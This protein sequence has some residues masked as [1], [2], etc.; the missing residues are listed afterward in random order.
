LEK[1]AEKTSAIQSLTG[2]IDRRTALYNQ[3][4][5]DYEAAKNC[6]GYGSLAEAEETEKEL[7]ATLKEQTGYESMEALKT[8]VSMDQRLSEKLRGE[9]V[10]VEKLREELNQTEEELNAL[11]K[12]RPKG[13]GRLQYSRKT[14]ERVKEEQERFEDRQGEVVADIASNKAKIGEVEKTLRDTK[15]GY[16]RYPSLIREVETFEAR[17]RL[18]ERVGVEL[19][20]TSRGLRERVL[21]HAAYVINHILPDITDGRYSDLKISEDLQFTVHSME[22]GEYKDRDVFSGGT[23]DQFLIALRLAFTQSILDSRIQADNYCLL[24]DECISSS[25]EPRKQGIFNVL[26][27]MKNTFRQIFIIAH[28]DISNLV[29]YHLVLA[30][31]ENGYTQIRSKSW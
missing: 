30:R 31:D 6:R 17:I 20:M 25:D 18:L 4:R 13:V 22:A 7:A 29:D 21:P 28:E 5:S 8:A 23:Q 10:G 12:T 9:A 11:V 19:D 2:E 3:L 24:M 14:H 27:A 16:E 1:V 26:E 15:S